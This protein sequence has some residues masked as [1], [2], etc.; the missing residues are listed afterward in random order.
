MII[1]IWVPKL[2]NQG[3]AQGISMQST[4]HDSC[5]KALH[6][7]HMRC[8]MT[9]GK[10]TCVW[11][12]RQVAADDDQLPLALRDCQLLCQPGQ[13]LCAGAS[14]KFDKAPGWSLQ[15]IRAV[16]LLQVMP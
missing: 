16:L 7:W 12:Q 6:Q 3:Y 13:L 11:V 1:H 14:A 8:A 10:L 5:C 15:P 4:P 9:Y 2:Y